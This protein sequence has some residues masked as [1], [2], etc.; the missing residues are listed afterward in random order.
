DRKAARLTRFENELRQTTELLTADQ[1]AV[2]PILATGL[3]GNTVY[4]PTSIGKPVNED[5]A[6]RAV[7]QI[8]METL[9][10]DTGGK[11]FY[12]ANALDEAMA[13][14]VDEGSHYYTLA[15]AP[16]NSKR[17]GK[18]RSVE[19]KTTGGSY[20]LAYRHGYYAANP[21]YGPAD[22]SLGN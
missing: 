4:D 15:Y 8:A 1:V 9:A 11:A 22:D 18:Y 13:H 21:S 14:A 12:N 2:Y 20:K 10:R 6:D 7:N 3:N 16:S 17:D 5:A 19:L